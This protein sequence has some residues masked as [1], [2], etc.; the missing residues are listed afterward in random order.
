M[1][2]TILESITEINSISELQN[3]SEHKNILQKLVYIVLIIIVLFCLYKLI[4]ILYKFITTKK[5]IIE[6]KENNVKK[7]S[8]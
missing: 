4:D 3:P 8:T 5:I 6:D 2:D 1:S 7:I